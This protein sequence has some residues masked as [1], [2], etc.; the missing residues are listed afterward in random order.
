[1]IYG[2]INP[3]SPGFNLIIPRNFNV[4]TN[5]FTFTKNSGNLYTWVYF[6]CSKTERF[7]KEQLSKPDNSNFAHV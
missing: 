3:Q 6:Y 2:Q 4:T 5:S 1:M 7:M